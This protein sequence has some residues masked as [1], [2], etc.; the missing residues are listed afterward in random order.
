MS[1][2]SYHK[3]PKEYGDYK[4]LIKGED[5]IAVVLQHLRIIVSVKYI[6]IK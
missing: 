5:T 4:D 2:L 6:L 1:L 3:I